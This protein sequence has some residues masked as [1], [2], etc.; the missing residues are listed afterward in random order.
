MYIYIPKSKLRPDVHDGFLGTKTEYKE[1]RLRSKPPPP[2]NE[3]N[4]Y[5]VCKRERF[6]HFLWT[7][8]FKK[9]HPFFCWGR[10]ACTVVNYPL[11]NVM[12]II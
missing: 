3:E 5:F 9:F 7:L 12:H 11:Y 4:L 8:K 10:K 1:R 6:K 2:L